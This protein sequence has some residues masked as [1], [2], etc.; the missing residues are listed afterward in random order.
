MVD[1]TM[2][3]LMSPHVFIEK[4]NVASEN[5]FEGKN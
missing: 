3:I 5:T 2:A 4:E 1:M